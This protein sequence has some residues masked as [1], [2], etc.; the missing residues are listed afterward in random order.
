LIATIAQKRVSASAAIKWKQRDRRNTFWAI[1][2]IKWKPGLTEELG[3]YS[4]SFVTLS[5]TKELKC[6]YFCKLKV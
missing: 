1:V 4:S 2:A 5:S 6:F 3:I